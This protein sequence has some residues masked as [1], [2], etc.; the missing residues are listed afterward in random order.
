[1]PFFA[2]LVTVCTKGVMGYEDLLYQEAYN[3]SATSLK[4]SKV[5]ICILSN[6]ATTWLAL[7]VAV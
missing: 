6:P 3:A 2:G 7:T 5:G 1:M 4:L